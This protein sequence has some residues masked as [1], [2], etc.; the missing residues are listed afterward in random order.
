MKRTFAVVS[1]A[2][3]IVAGLGFVGIRRI[4]QSLGGFGGTMFG[5]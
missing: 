2:V 3:L 4:Q 1:A 5:R